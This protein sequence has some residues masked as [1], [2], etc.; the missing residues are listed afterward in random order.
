MRLS[1][2]ARA[3]IR[4]RATPEQVEAIRSLAES[5]DPAVRE[6]FQ[7]MREAVDE[8]D[9]GLEILGPYLTL[10][11][12]EARCRQVLASLEAEVP[13]I[14]D[15]LQGFAV[16]DLPDRM[17]ELV[18]AWNRGQEAVAQFLVAGTVRD[19]LIGMVIERAR[20][21]GHAVA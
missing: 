18:A 10:L 8:F 6:V 19:I 5:D 2:R 15:V 16:L 14:R 3:W 17:R 1:A 21:D 20:R 12:D 13:A 11:H 9:A 7:A 4:R